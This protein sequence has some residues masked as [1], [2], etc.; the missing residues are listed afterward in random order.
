VRAAPQCL[1][2]GLHRI[3]ICVKLV[4]LAALDRFGQGIL[5]VKW[6]NIFGSSRALFQPTT[7]LWV[8]GKG[9]RPRVRLSGP[10]R[11][12]PTFAPVGGPLRTCVAGHAYEPLERPFRPVPAV[13]PL[14]GE[15]NPKGKREIGEKTCCRVRCSARI[16][17]PTR[18]APVEPNNKTH[19]ATHA[20]DT[21]RSRRALARVDKGQRAPAASSVGTVGPCQ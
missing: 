14:W 5:L 2:A 20:P 16:K 7:S 9:H 17:S 11:K 8:D 4:R 6:Q 3:C 18:L 15:V 13:L 10:P 12:E 1:A 19:F 21:R